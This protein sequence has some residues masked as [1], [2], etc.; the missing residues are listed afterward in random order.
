[1]SESLEILGYETRFAY[2]ALEALANVALF[3]PQVM[4]IDI[5]MT[6]MDGYDLVR[7]LR[8]IVELGQ[9]RLIAVTG[10]VRVSD[11]DRALAAGFDEHIAKPSILRVLNSFCRDSNLTIWLKSPPALDSSLLAAFSQ[12]TV[13]RAGVLPRALARFQDN[14]ITIIGISD[15]VSR[16]ERSAWI[17]TFA[18][19]SIARSVSPGLEK[20]SAA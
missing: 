16:C 18:D 14:R 12:D 19:D 5:E 2:D 8:A 1:M 11:R 13:G 6:G 7:R 17:P 3:Q 15:P 10:R 9:P 4:F 20:M